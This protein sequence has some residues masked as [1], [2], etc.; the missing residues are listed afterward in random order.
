[1][2][3]FKTIFFVLSVVLLTSCDNDDDAPVAEDALPETVSAYLQ[4]HFKNI[5]IA[6]TTRDREDND[7]DVFLENGVK[8]EFSSNDQVES[9][10]STNKL[11]DSVIPVKILDYVTLN[12]PDEYITEWELEGNGQEIQL[13]NKLE[14]KFNKAG[15][16]I[17]IDS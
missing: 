9:I 10:K 12:Y 3:V 14:L 17:K 15:D 4:T 8:L 1:M 6:R 2:N 13:S 7:Y 11:P 16:F 5:A